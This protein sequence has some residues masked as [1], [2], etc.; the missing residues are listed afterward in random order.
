MFEENL[1][2]KDW[3]KIDL[4]FGLIYPNMYQ[5]G[6]SSYSIRL[7]YFMI[8]SNPNYVCERFFL[9]ENIKYP[10]SDDNSSIN[11]IRSIETKLLP[12]DFDILGFSV[13]Y[14][15]NFKNILWML[16]KAQIP[17]ESEK[18]LYNLSR[19]SEPY[20]LVIGGGPA[21]TSNPLPMS[22][23]FDLFFIGDAGLNFSKFE[24]ITNSSISII[25]EK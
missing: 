16:E 8:N 19:K 9:P 21:I 1:I 12:T 10:A 14:E 20:P 23:V 17:L 5:L 3:R 4:S 7:L 11:R 2:I 13:H 15:N 24:S 6:M 18:R 25:I 22:K